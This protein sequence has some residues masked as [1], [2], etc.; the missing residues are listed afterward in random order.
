MD[1]WIA[2]LLVW[3]AFKGGLFIDDLQEGAEGAESHAALVLVV[4]G[5][6][7]ERTAHD[8][9]GERR[10]WIARGVVAVGLDFGPHVIELLL[11]QV[12]AASLRAGAGI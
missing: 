5:A 3:R 7:A 11:V 9:G 12:C 10:L 6:H 4:V 1:G 2:Y 8:A